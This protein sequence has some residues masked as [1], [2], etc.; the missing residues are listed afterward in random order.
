MRNAKQMKKKGDKKELE[1]L[2]SMG[3]VCDDEG[4]S[5]NAIC[6]LLSSLLFFFLGWNSCWGMKMNR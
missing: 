1:K 5:G 4:F 3:D 6:T 2:F